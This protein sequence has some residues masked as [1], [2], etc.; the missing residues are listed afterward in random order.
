MSGA[1]RLTDWVAAAREVAP[2]HEKRERAVFRVEVAGRVGFAKRG[3]GSKRREVRREASVHRSLLDRGL[4]VI[5][6]LAAGDEGDATWLVTAAAP[7]APLAELLVDAVERGD[8]RERRRLLRVAAGALAVFHRADVSFADATATHLFVAGDRAHWID[9]A[10]AT[11]H[12]LGLGEGT[13]AR[14]L[15]ALLFSVPPGVAS[16][17]ERVRWLRDATGRSGDDLR[18]LWP[19]VERRLRRLARRTR[20]RHRYAT[21]D[22]GLRRDLSARPLFDAL[23]DGHGWTVLR[24]LDDRENRCLGTPGSTYFA[25]RYPAVASG[26]SPGMTEILA[27]DLFQ[28]AGVPCCHVVGYAEDVERGS[29]AV[30]RAVPGR[31]LDDWLR[32]GASPA[33]RRDVARRLGVLFGRLRSAG[34]RHRDAYACHVFVAPRADGSHELHLIDLTRAGPAPFPAERWFV[35]DASQLWH[36]LRGTSATRQDAVR[37]L[38]AYFGLARLDATAKRFARRVVAKERRIE[39][40]QRRKRAEAGR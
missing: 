1:P 39:A 28:R 9:L 29:V 27:A 19:A 5:D 22:A 2:V 34:L 20:W 8:H 12:R 35:K 25:K 33:A 13:R 10:R 26:W 36:G 32:E 14:D 16:R 37:F 23:L 17:R 24:T 18:A 3:T 7:G 31:P 21:A 6:V 11:V 4:P 30:T 38:Q 15:A 40:R